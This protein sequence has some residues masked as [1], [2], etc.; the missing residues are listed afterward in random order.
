MARKFSELRSKMAPDSQ[1]RAKA[2]TAEMLREVRLAELRKA[3]DLTQQQLAA[4]LK[5]NQAWISKVEHQA[6]MYLSTLRAYV[7]A[8][9]GELEINARFGEEIIRIQHIDR[10][11]VEQAAFTPGESLNQ[12][13]EPNREQEAVKVSVYQ[14]IE[15]R[16]VWHAGVSASTRQAGTTSADT[17]PATSKAA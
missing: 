6:D 3:R 1:V 10:V 11:G 14:D 15:H 2:R 13:P 5:V 12:G 4:E 16:G 7:E 8:V 9:G 17:T